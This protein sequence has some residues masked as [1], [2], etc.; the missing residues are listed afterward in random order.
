MNPTNPL[1]PYLKSFQEEMERQFYSP[2]RLLVTANLPAY[3]ATHS[4]FIFRRFVRFIVT[5][6]VGRMNPSTPV[7]V[8]ERQ[9]L[10][11]SYEWYLRRQ[12]RVSSRTIFHSWRIADRFVTLRFA[13]GSAIW[14][15]SER[16]TSSPSCNR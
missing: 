5:N 8:T 9:L 14:R 6:G 10:K 1:T 16:P 13:M 12:R 4:R 3:R 11:Q 15:R 7:A 2:L